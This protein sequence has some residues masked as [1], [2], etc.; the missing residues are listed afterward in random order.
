MVVLPLNVRSQTDTTISVTSTETPIV[1]GSPHSL[2]TG[3]GYGSNLIY[4]GSTLSQNQS[5]GYG[6]LSYGFK[7]AVFATVSAVNLTG[8]NEFPAF[9]IGSL[10]YS[11]TF[12]SWFDVSAGIYRYQFA[13]SL[14]DTLFSNFFYC[15]LTLGFDWKL[16]YSKISAGSLF[17]YGNQ[18]YF[19]I[20]NSR[21]FQTPAFSKKKVFF[22]FDPYVNLLFGSLTRIET[23][24]DTIITI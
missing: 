13:K 14:L 18:G 24:T 19:Q 16:L 4:L 7:D 8:L 9:Y 21:Y 10:S 11:H 15:D 3:L 17:S 23:S 12:N 5:Y 2:Y 20:R 22:S 6:T 1:K